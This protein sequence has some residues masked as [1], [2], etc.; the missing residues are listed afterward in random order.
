MYTFSPRSAC[1]GGMSNYHYNTL[2]VEGP[3]KGKLLFRLRFGAD[4]IRA[5]GSVF[6]CNLV[7]DPD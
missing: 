4:L 1:G 3:P 5:N 6:Y 7:G 2:F